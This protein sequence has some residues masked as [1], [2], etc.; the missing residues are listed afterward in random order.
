MTLE[1]FRLWCL[2]LGEVE[3]KTPFG[4]FAARYDSILVF[5]VLGHMFCFVDIDNFDS[6]TIK[7]SPEDI[8]FL[9]ENF[10]SVGLPENQSLKHW[11]RIFLG[12]DVPT[13]DILKHVRQSFEIVKEKYSPKI[14]KMKKS[15]SGSKNLK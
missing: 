15:V 2:Q 11:I 8:E 6:V 10:F 9:R 12:G 4:K 5:Y 14:P 13:D 1:D 3:E 7:A